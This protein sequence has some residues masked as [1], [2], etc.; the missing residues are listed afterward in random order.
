LIPSDVSALT[1]SGV[2]VLVQPSTMRIYKDSEFR[3]AGAELVE[4]VGEANT[5]LG[6]KEFPKE[7]LIKD[8]AYMIFSHTIKAQPY[9][10]PFLDTVSNFCSNCLHRSHVSV[11]NCSDS[12]P[13]CCFVLSSVWIVASVCSTTRR[14]A[15][16]RSRAV[17]V[18]AAWWPS[19]SSQALLA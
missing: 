11:C 2:R 17:V 7:K 14:S 19:E 10:M 15:L 18:A 5:I 6:V 13:L 3:A 4:D 16:L 12:H 9:N 8:K 1:K